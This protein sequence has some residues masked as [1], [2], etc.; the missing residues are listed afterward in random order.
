[1][2]TLKELMG[3]K[4]RGDGR[5]F[6]LGND[7]W[8]EPIFKDRGGEWTGLN[9]DGYCESFSEGQIYY[10][11]EWTPPKQTKKVKLYC[12]IYEAYKG[13]IKCYGKWASK[14]DHFYELAGN[15][16]IIGWQEM[17]V[18]VDE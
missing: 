6:T 18:E 1:M 8:F 4:I 12:P 3:D 13:I 10:W 11:E 5:K 16:R 9:E 17:E 2:A 14:K 15:Q 7:R